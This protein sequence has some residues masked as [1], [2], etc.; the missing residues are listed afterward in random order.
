MDIKNDFSIPDVLFKN[1]AAVI[2][3]I[4]PSTGQIF[5]ANPAAVCFYGWSREQLQKMNIRDVNNLSEKE[6]FGQ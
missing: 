1:H 2:L 6:L 4:D 3:I 5:D